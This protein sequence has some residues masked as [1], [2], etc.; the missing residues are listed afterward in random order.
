MP[1]AMADLGRV[2]VAVRVRPF[3]ARENERSAKLIIK[4]EGAKTTITDPDCGREH[5]FTFDYSY[6]SHTPTEPRKDEADQQTVYNDLGT[7]CLESAWAGYNVSLFA[8]GQTG[9]GKSFSMIGYG[10]EEGIIP[11]VSRDIF[12][13]INA[14][15]DPSVTFK[16]QAAMLE[17]Y[18]EKV[19]DL[20]NPGNAPPGG[21]KV[22]EHPKLGPFVEGLS[23]LLV[24]DNAEVVQLMEMGTKARTI[25]STNMNA[26]SSRAHTI[27]TVRLTQTRIDKAKGTATDRV[28]K[29]SLV[30]LAGSERVK[31]TGSSAGSDRMKEGININK[32]L[33]SLGLCIK[34]LAEKAGGSS[35][36]VPYRNSV[37]TWLLKESLGGNARTVMIAALSPADINYDETLS[38]LRYAN[39]AKAIKNVAIVNED[40]NEKAIRELKDEVT[41]LRAQLEGGNKIVVVDEESAKRAAELEEQLAASKALIAQMG[42]SWEEKE[43][44]T[45]QLQSQ[46]TKELAA[47]GISVDPNLKKLPQLVNLNE[48]HS[49]SEC[50]VYFLKDGDTLVG[51]QDS[52]RTNQVCLQGL[53]VLN[54]HC[55]ITNNKRK[56]TVFPEPGAKL[57]VNG[58][59]VDGPTDLQHGTRIVFGNS[60]FFRYSDPNELARIRKEREKRGVTAGPE[61]VDFEFAQNEMIAEKMMS[62]VKESMEA[63]QALAAANKELASAEAKMA[64]ERASMMADMEKEREKLQGG[65]SKAEIEAL[66]QQMQQQQEQFE[67]AMQEKEASLEAKRMQMRKKE[68]AERQQALLEDELGRVITLVEE[69]N[70][71]SAEMHRLTVFEAKVTTSLDA[72]EA[73]PRAVVQVL[74]KFIKL[75]RYGTWEHDK[76]ANRIYMMR[77]MYSESQSDVTYLT[78]VDQD[79]DPFYDPPEN[80][81]IGVAHIYLESLGFMLDIQQNTPL[82]TDSGTQAGTLSLDIFPCGPGGSVDDVPEIDAPEDLIGKRMDLLFHINGAKGLSGPNKR[83]GSYVRY[84]FFGDEDFEETREAQASASPNYGYKRQLTFSPATRELIK[85]VQQDHLTVELW[86]VAPGEDEGK[87][88]GGGSSGHERALATKVKELEDKL[89][90]SNQHV[91]QLEMDLTRSQKSGGAAPAMFSQAEIT[92]M[93]MELANKNKALK[94][95]ASQ[96]LESKQQLATRA[97]VPTASTQATNAAEQAMMQQEL[98]AARDRLELLQE[99]SAS[100]RLAKQEL[101]VELEAQ[102][103]AQRKADQELA[104]LR[105]Q[106]ADMGEGGGSKACN[107][108]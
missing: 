1:I 46:R 102:S 71:L 12:T 64:A 75:N 61:I 56:I 68:I 31:G 53:G 18:N 7:D 20:F 84:R 9:S 99:M 106:V 29:I 25:A 43:K 60:I 86:S 103:E 10:E 70:M 8:Y 28:S 38:T 37:L 27:F 78:T 94:E 100:D 97:D 17:I 85:Y 30:D 74:V 50:L 23:E 5:P 3:N 90:N 47:M 40:P 19:K 89:V 107:L 65:A 98:E 6:W 58:K 51:R 81:L 22:R 91:K 15:T 4:M 92:K 52:T 41:R 21:L 59:A 35:V 83:N 77:E 95:L 72:L 104:A 76:L 57:H 101:E 2:R 62:S 87:G 39:S 48:D 79:D 105:A 96:L 34:T 93:M 13:R 63:K 80:Q 88:G 36:S 24:H 73:G 49:M 14:G 82:V 55:T 69:A 54:E 11:R 45:A 26:T 16:V 108:Q 42:K 33:S 67:R 32:S 44:E 66:Q